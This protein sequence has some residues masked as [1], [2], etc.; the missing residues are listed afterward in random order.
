M[1]TSIVVFDIHFWH[2][3]IAAGIG[4]AFKPV[5]FWGHGL[6]RSRMGQALRRICLLWGKGVIVYGDAGRRQC[7]DAGVSADRVFVA[8]NT[9]VVPG[10]ADS[11]NEEKKYFLFVGR[12]HKRK[13]LDVL[14]KAYADYVGSVTAPRQDLKIVGSGAISESLMKLAQELGVASHVCFVP[15]TT[16][17]EELAK[18]FRHAI[19]YV[20]PGHVGLGVLHSFAFGVPVVTFCLDTH[21]PEFENVVHD[22]NGLV[23]SGSQSALADSLL[24]LAEDRRMSMRLG[25]EA[26]KTYT[27][28]AHPDQMVATFVEALQFAKTGKRVISGE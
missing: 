19:A 5:L 3:L 12:L 1:I 8:R 11:S 7:T 27:E 21:A 6:G 22:V 10:Y 26:F 23:L 4:S 28:K 18:I 24:E 25:K 2:V 13:R 15:G 17:P 20:S 14:L 9:Q 16:D